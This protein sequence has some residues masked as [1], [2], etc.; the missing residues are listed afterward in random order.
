MNIKLS[1]QSKDEKSGKISIIWIQT[2]T[3][4]R[5]RTRIE[6]I[7]GWCMTVLEDE[8]EAGSLTT[9]W[10]EEVGA[11][12]C[13]LNYNYNNIRYHWFP[14]VRS[15]PSLRSKHPSNLPNSSHRYSFYCTLPGG[16]S[17]VWNLPPV[18][19]STRRKRRHKLHYPPRIQ[20]F[21]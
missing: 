16:R 20:T 11:A 12:H 14:Q 18:Y 10:E 17:N 4:R 8:L 15:K 13:R 21:F 5:T 7:S 9:S 6:K 2:R 1:Q 19:R 3:R